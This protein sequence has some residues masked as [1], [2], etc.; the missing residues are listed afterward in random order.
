[1]IKN[2]PTALLFALEDIKH[3]YISDTTIM[4]ISNA[5]N[6]EHLPILRFCISNSK[7]APPISRAD[8]VKTIHVDIDMQRRTIVFVSHCDESCITA[9]IHVDICGIVNIKSEI[10][11]ILC[12]EF[13]LHDYV[14]TADNELVVTD[15]NSDKGVLNIYKER[16]LYFSNVDDFV[17]KLYYVVRND[18]SKFSAISYKSIVE[19]FNAYGYNFTADENVDYEVLY[20]G[21][22]TDIA[23]AFS[24]KQKYPDVKDVKL[25]KDDNSGKYN[26]VID[27]ES[28]DLP[29]SETAGNV[30]KHIDGPELK[31]GYVSANTYYDN[32]QLPAVLQSMKNKPKKTPTDCLRIFILERCKYNKGSKAFLDDIYNDY[33]E[34][35]S[36]KTGALQ[37]STVCRIIKQLFPGCES[38]THES[39]SVFFD[40]EYRPIEDEKRDISDEQ[41]VHYKEAVMEFISRG[42]VHDVNYTTTSVDI[43]QAFNS[44]C[45]N[46]RIKTS[47]P[48]AKEFFDF[49]KESIKLKHFCHII[50][51]NNGSF[52]MSGVKLV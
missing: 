1:M 38:G 18:K 47:I 3:C 6:N 32:S 44:Y 21:L 17:S 20:A 42:I 39:Q 24:N 35:A 50:E 27:L 43:L 14:F 22:F 26:V 51:R 2:L 40:M 30:S 16:D 10:Y 33:K 34:Y 13:Y 12:K 36:D 25:I 8:F 23:N 45:D 7:D 11:K 46:N 9:A 4:K 48:S 41:P 31:K 49:F 5:S 29:S 15:I 28:E 37:I 52:E 19:S